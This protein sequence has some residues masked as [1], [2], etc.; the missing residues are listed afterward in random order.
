MI[1]ALIQ[2]ASK[3]IIHVFVGKMVIPRN[4]RTALNNSWF[5]QD[6]DKQVDRLK[7]QAYVC[8][9]MIPQN[10]FQFEHIYTQISCYSVIIAMVYITK[11]NNHVHIMLSTISCAIHYN[12]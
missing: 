2:T 6:F 11:N 8:T 10:L 5:R 1:H 4:G 9:I 7:L 12:A 3:H